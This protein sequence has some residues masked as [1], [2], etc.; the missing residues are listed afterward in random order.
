MGIDL[1]LLVTFLRGVTDDEIKVLQIFM[2]FKQKHLL[3]FNQTV[4]GDTDI[5]LG[6]LGKGGK[7]RREISHKS[8]LKTSVQSFFFIFFIFT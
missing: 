8:D 7:V 5:T 6:T 3:L 1:F 4:H 2:H